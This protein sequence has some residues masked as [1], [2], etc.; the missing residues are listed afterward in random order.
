MIAEIGRA[1]TKSRFAVPILY[2]HED[3]AR[4]AATVHQIMGGDCA[5]QF[6]FN[7]LKNPE[8]KRHRTDEFC[9]RSVRD[10]A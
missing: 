1:S 4:A 8:P 2:Y 10:S 7:H 5:R 3:C 9:S 6:L